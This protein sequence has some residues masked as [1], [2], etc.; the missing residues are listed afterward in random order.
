MSKY[1]SIIFF[2]FLIFG[3]KKDVDIVRNNPVPPVPKIK[4]PTL[5]TNDIS[6]LTRY[7][8]ILSGKIIDTGMASI[9]EQGFVV[10]TAS[11]PTT[12]RNLYKFSLRLDSTVTFTVMVKGFPAN[13]KFYVR[14]YGSNPYGVGYGNEINFNSFQ[15]NIFR[16]NV[17]LTTQKQVV[18][19]GAHGYSRIYGALEIEGP[20]TDL[21]P[22]KNL[23]VVDAGFSVK[24]T[25]LENFNGLDSLEFTGYIFKNNFRVENN[26][27]LVNFSGL[28]K[29]SI[30]G[31]Y[32]YVLNNN[33][34]L[35][36]DGLDNFIA[37]GA[38]ELRIQDCSKLQNVNGFKKMVFIGG[39]LGLINNPSL[40][41]ITGFGNLETVESLTFI[42]DAAL[43]NLDGLEK[44]KSLPRGLNFTNNNSLSDLK[45]LTNLSTVGDNNDAGAILINGNAALKDLSVFRNINKADYIT[46]QNN[47]LLQNLKGLDNIE[48]ISH[49]LHI[50]GNSS[51]TALSGLEKLASVSRLEI[52]ANN[53]LINLKG[54]ES[55]K[56]IDKN[57]YSIII[58]SNDKLESLSGLENLIFVEGTIG[59][60]N[61]ISL[62]DFCP[63]KSLFIKGYNNSFLTADNVI[64]PTQNDILN[65]CP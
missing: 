24:N 7:T 8:V 45:G 65:G 31:G 27:N 42:N 41:D 62:S 32:F 60:D 46:I 29:L 59:I 37:A 17:S 56:I 1:F 15:E 43:R 48:S 19:F 61:N 28:T 57:A 54:L 36:M 63:L 47:G 25:L 34:L 18:D 64:N 58:H 2:T 39:Y 44:I 9:N 10:D 11:M 5:T 38:G 23:V 26:Q 16:G 4:I 49:N 30:T 14:A 52:S 21:S 55:L 13:T 12:I 3:C 33:S 22:L 35:N 50:E 53:S 6:D 40:T 51:L 20:I